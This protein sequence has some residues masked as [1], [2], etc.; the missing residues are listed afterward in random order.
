MQE[1][2]TGVNIPAGRQGRTAQDGEHRP[3][4]CRQEDEVQC[5][6]SEAGG[7]GPRQ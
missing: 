7:D 5:G 6:H 3:G 4:C 2:K 1:E